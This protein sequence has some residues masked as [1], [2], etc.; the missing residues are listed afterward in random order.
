M[1]SA[2]FFLLVEDFI[3]WRLK[4]FSLIKYVLS[5]VNTISLRGYTLVD[6]EQSMGN[7]LFFFKDT[8]WE[9]YRFHR[10]RSQDSRYNAKRLPDTNTT[11][12]LHHN[13]HRPN[14]MDSPCTV[15]NQEWRGGDTPGLLDRV[16]TEGIFTRP[17][18][19]PGGT[20]QRTAHPLAPKSRQVSS[21][22]KPD[23]R[24]RR[25]WSADG[26][27]HSAL[28]APAL[29]NGC[30]QLQ[31]AHQRLHEPPRRRPQEGKRCSCAAA[32]RTEVRL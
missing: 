14:D 16:T 17:T 4:A 23:Q 27:V 11:H 21:G 9:V 5:F 19:T 25:P 3:P 12:G 1:M 15:Y 24:I 26:G 31:L 20:S 22:A 13:P 2:G 7:S 30:H 10:S 28:K 6:T 18:Q 8:P 29:S 32:A